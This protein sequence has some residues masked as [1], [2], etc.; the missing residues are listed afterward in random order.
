MDPERLKIYVV[1][2]ETLAERSG[3]KSL[4]E[5]VS[6]ILLGGATA[7]QLRGKNVKAKDLVAHGGRIRA[8]TADSGALLIVN[9]RLDVALAVGADG[10]HLGA[11]D[12]PLAPARK[13]APRGFI[14]G[15]SVDTPDEARQAEAEGAD[16]LGA[17]PVFPTETKQTSNPVIGPAGLEAIVKAVS[18]P[19]VGIG[20]IN[21][22][23]VGEVISTGAAGAAVASAVVS[24]ADPEAAVRALRSSSGMA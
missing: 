23:N 24:S 16:Y 8:L 21:P 6:A 13:I 19:V 9:D 4:Q 22:G 1:V 7:I 18:I 15:G 14:I 17:G 3:H 20:G 10:V 2:D 11:D 12:L 5:L